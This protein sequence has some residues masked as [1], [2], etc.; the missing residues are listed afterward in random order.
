MV[1]DLNIVRDAALFACVLL[2]SFQSVTA[3]PSSEEV[4]ELSDDDLHMVVLHHLE[5]RAEALRN[6]DAKSETR[7]ANYFFHNGHRGQQ[8]VDNGRFL[9][10]IKRID[11]SY[12]LD[13]QLYMDQNAATVQVDSQS[14]FDDSN[15][16]SRNVTKN[17]SIENK[18]FGRIDS[19]QDNTIVMDRGAYFLAGASDVNKENF[20]SDLFDASDEWQLEHTADNDF[21]EIRFPYR[22]AE[23]ETRGIRGVRTVLLDKSKEMMPVRSTLEWEMP[24]KEDGWRF[25]EAIMKEPKKYGELWIPTLYEETVRASTLGDDKCTFQVTRVSDISLGTVMKA[26]LELSFPPGTNVTDAL[27]GGSYTVGDDG[28]P[29][30]QLMPF[31]EPSDIATNDGELGVSYLFWGNVFLVV[32]LLAAYFYRIHHRS[33]SSPS[34]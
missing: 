21:I 12:L 4:A 15:G 3:A 28:L 1:Q 9:F 24:T 10:H 8:D 27:K 30:G 13:A 20:F 6:I 11:G 23:L 29:L 19:V 16:I 5:E 17:A 2:A 14:N 32:F 7:S 33:L 26:D 25:E 31:H 34:S 18:V 22:R